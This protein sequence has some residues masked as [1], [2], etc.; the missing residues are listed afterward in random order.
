MLLS[1]VLVATLS[2]CVS[3][4]R[5]PCGSDA[6]RD[7]IPTIVPSRLASLPHTHTSV[8]II[9][10][11]LDAPAFAPH[12]L[13]VNVHLPPGYDPNATVRYP[14]LY[15][16]DGQDSAAVGLTAALTQLY[17][18]NAIRKPIV[19]AIDMPADRMGAYGLSDRSAR[20]S[21]PGDSRFDTVGAQAHAYSEWVATTLVPYIDTR[22]RTQPTA[23]S[24]AMLGWSLGALNA[25]NLGWQYPEV[26][27]TVGALSPSFWLSGDRTDAASIQRSRLAQRMVQ[28][29]PKR[30]G[31]RFWVAVGSA[32]ETDDRDGD[33][34]IDAVD[35]TRDLA[36][37]LAQAGYSANLEYAQRP[38]N[39][40]EVA[41]YLLPDGQHNQSSW[42]R[43]LPH[44]L[45]W[46]YGEAP[47]VPFGVTGRVEKHPSFPSGH[48]QARNVEVWL[49]PG[50]GDNSA[51]RYPVLYLHDGQ[52]LFDP[53]QSDSGVD[54]GVDDTMTRLIGEE[55]VCAAIVVGIWNTPLRLAEYM[56]AKA[57]PGSGIPMGAGNARVRRQDVISDVYLA[58][59]VRELKPFIDRTCRTL[60]TR[61]D[62]FVMGS[63]M[64]GLISA[65][66]ISEYPQVFGGAGCIFHALAGG[67]GHSDRLPGQASAGS[68]HAQV[69]FRPRHRDPG[70]QLRSVSTAHGRVDAPG[71]LQTGHAMDDAQLRGSGTFRKILACATRNT[72]AVSAGAI[73]RGNPERISGFVAEVID[74]VAA[75]HFFFK[76]G[77][78]RLANDYSQVRRPRKSQRV[79]FTE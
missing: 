46:A 10:I 21:T 37:A 14:V 64:G 77:L 61:D 9:R 23:Q 65:Y 40:E 25:F 22:Y 19:V 29:G 60:P 12:P 72:T 36:R 67:R 41:L 76:F 26:F 20:K 70:R 52:S 7:G 17:A 3:T 16:N 35:D 5:K 53:A 11:E 48:V 32:E 31:L 27:G 78:A 71:W 59:L 47:A 6:S 15:L 18:E 58:F 33:G 34:T 38:T 75:Q 55:K 13:K 24:R 66:T 39:Q 57:M 30:E 42:A 1:I 63:S 62:T 45:Q 79:G 28:A 4:S 8:S 56:P 2:A 74:Q 50:Y 69:L 51:R 49:P 73:A 54:W 44:F 68:A 43:M